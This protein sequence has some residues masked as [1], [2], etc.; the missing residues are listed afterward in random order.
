MGFFFGGG[1]VIDRQNEDLQG[2]G[3]FGREIGPDLFFVY[4]CN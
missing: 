4:L 3:S 2:W 1:G